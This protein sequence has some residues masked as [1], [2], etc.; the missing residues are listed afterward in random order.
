MNRG[1][2]FEGAGRTAPVREHLSVAGRALPIEYI[3]HPRARRYVLRLR[4]DGSVR[5]SVP[6]RGSLQ[7]ARAFAAEHTGWLERQLRRW[8]GRPEADRRWRAGQLIF[9]RGERVLLRAETGPTGLI[10]RWA[11]QELRLPAPVEDL[12]PAVERHLQALAARELPARVFALAVTQNLPVRRVQVRDQHTRWGSCSRRG[13]VSLNWRLVQMPP[14]VCDYV[15][16]HE[17]MHLREM[18][19]SRRF[20]RLVAAVC[21]DFE[22]ARR[23]LRRHGEGLRGPSLDTAGRDPTLPG[24]QNPTGI[25]AVIFDMDGVLTDSEPLI[26]AA[27]VAM[28]HERGIPVAPEDFVP[29]IGTGEN[30]YIGGVA[31][32]YGVSLDLEAAK[33]RTYEI[34]LELVPQ[35]L[36][37]FPGAVELVRACRAAGRRVAV[38]SSADRVKIEANLRQ[39]GLPPETWDTVVSAEDAVHKKPAP[40]LFLAAARKLGLPP[41]ACVVIEDAVNGVQAAKA[42]GMRCVAVAHSFPPERLAAA[43]RVRPRIAEVMPADLWGAE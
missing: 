28:F 26:N 14:A 40:D 38:A 23:W 13:T 7:A 25:R 32:K 5:V 30:R 8:A 2:Q 20:W 41:A 4:A 18:N 11:D 24:V 12:R 21:P 37:A 43:D 29:F 17:L 1:D 42:A 22:A 19:H 15:I 33:R 34:Y 3:P 31:E 27:A 39:I 36:R 9:F 35:R 10:V 6:R 16:W